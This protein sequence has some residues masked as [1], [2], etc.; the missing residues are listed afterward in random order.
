V[1]PAAPA[2]AA[3]SGPVVQARPGASTTLVTE[4]PAPGPRTTG[5]APIVI[6]PNLIDRTTLLPQPPPRK[7]RGTRSSAGASAPVAGA[8]SAAGTGPAASGA[9]ASAAEAQ[10][11]AATQAPA[12]D[13]NR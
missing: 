7:P 8:A 5:T 10:L 11:G 9:A 13:A 12:A 1:Q 4:A 3:A 6:P 2:T